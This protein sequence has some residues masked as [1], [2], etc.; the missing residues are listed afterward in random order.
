MTT[1]PARD[2]AR[3]I[4]FVAE[5][6]PPVGYRCFY[7]LPSAAKPADEKNLTG[8]A[9]ENVFCRVRF[10]RGGIQGFYDKQ[11]KWEVLKTDKFDGAEVLEFSAPG[12]AWEDT[13][14]V[15]MQDF[16]RTADH[17]FRRVSF[18]ENPVRMTAIYE[19]Q[20][21]NFLL[22]E[23]F[24]LYRKIDRFDVNIEIVNWSG[25]KARELRVAFPINLDDVRSSYEVPFGTV[26][27]GK[28]ELDFTRLP[29]NLDSQFNPRL[30]GGTHALSFREAINWID[31]S[32]PDCAEAGC[33]A[34]SDS[35][36]HIFRDETPQPVPYPV[37]QHV[38]LSTRKS[39]AWNPEYWY[40]QKGNH[41]YRMALFPH[42]GNWR[43][44]YREAIGFNYPLMAFTSQETALVQHF[45]FPATQSFFTL[46]PA[47]LILTAMKKSEDDER[48]VIRFYEAEGNK[49]TA[50]IRL[51]VPVRQAWKASLIEENQATIDPSEDGSLRIVVSPWEIVTL[52]IAI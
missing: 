14:S 48:I 9:M 20:F 45:T 6:V 29:S 8:E 52:K 40:T 16:E 51:Q 4:V 43:L 35:T 7:L 22:R 49:S 42:G 23:R 12:N 10:G 15:E 38:L 31:A 5:D 44:R 3:Y 24:Q 19:A 17:D 32:S 21:K 37:L 18:T 28:D 11:H 34:A 50:C 41:Q 13:E 39:L 1:D 26:E 46:E 25:E 33:L 2:G 36:V 27:M 30:Y 47:N